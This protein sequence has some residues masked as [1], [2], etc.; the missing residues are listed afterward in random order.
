MTFITTR[1]QRRELERENARRPAHR[2]PGRD[3][4]ADMGQSNRERMT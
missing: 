2:A 1:A 4:D 3:A